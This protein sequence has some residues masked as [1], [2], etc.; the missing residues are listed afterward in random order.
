MNPRAMFL[1]V[2]AIVGAAIVFWPNPE[3]PRVARVAGAA[4]LF[5]SGIAIGR[6]L[7]R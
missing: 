6:E 1:F 7:A 3:F 2:A 4:L 5:G